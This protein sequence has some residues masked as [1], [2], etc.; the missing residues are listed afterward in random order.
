M[1]QFDPFAWGT[2]RPTPSWPSSLAR[3]LDWPVKPAMDLVED[4]GT[5]RLTAEIPGIDPKE[6]EIKV[7]GD[8]LTVRG[9]K[10]E[11]KEETKASY[12]VSE[13][14]YGAFERSLRLPQDVDANAID[15]RVTDG[16]LTVT[17]P[18]SAEAKA[19]ARRIE[20]KTG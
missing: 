19:S 11:Q 9:E 2:L 8:M 20:V 16:V 5:Y 6:I 15:A 14:R 17:L 1:G 3:R 10:K 13:R 4:D 18:K 7:T 12:R